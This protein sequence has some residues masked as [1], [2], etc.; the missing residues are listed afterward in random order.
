MLVVGSRGRGPGRAIVLGSVSREVAALA[1]RPVLIV[2]A[3]PRPS[4]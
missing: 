2:P 4:A 1:D 3:G